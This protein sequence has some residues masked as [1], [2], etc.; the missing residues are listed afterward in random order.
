[1][2][3]GANVMKKILIVLLSIFLL[4]SC[5][6]PLSPV[7]TP[8]E[9][10]AAAYIADL[11]SQDTA[12]LVGNYGYSSKMAQAVGE[13]LFA[14]IYADLAQWG[15]WQQTGNP[16]ESTQGEFRT[17]T[18][19][20]HFEK[21]ALNVNITFDQSNR[22]AGLHY[23]LRQK[24]PSYQPGVQ[25]IGVSFGSEPYVISGTLTLPAGGGPFP[26]VVL[27]QGSGPS[28]RDE[29]VGQNRPFYE[30]ASYL[31]DQGIATLRYDKRTFTYGSKLNAETI[32]PY[33]ETIADA[34]FAFDFLKMQP[35]IDPGRLFILGHSLGGYLMPLIAK[36]TPDAAGYVMAAAPS[37]R[38][39]D[40]MVMQYEY[41]FNLDGALTSDEK[42]QLSEIEMQRDAIR[43]LTPAS[44]LMSNDLLGAGKDYWLYLKDYDPVQAAQAIH[45]PLLFLQ[46]ERDYQVPV[47]QLE[48]YKA[49][50]AGRDSV[51]F[52]TYPGIN[53]LLYA[54]QG[55]PGP[56]EY[57]TPG[58]VSTRLLSDL[59]D[60]IKGH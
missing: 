38:M 19:P 50:L 6:A 2:G 18:Y 56:E 15:S 13:Q 16:E 28:N 5:S 36:D 22:I 25:G 1:M 31:A 42:A 39:E 40:L 27:V 47:S 53:H 7:K 23:V 12:A 58:H 3:R 4:A 52:K 43:K 51:T 10:T 44:M 60:W 9:Q 35:D 20:V 34:V 32:T 59:A 54:G 29:A 30:I 14:A 49:A 57:N 46:G 48:P 17:I 37:S 24:E 26:A 8:I 41:I 11:K 21:G 33:D 45:T 55:T